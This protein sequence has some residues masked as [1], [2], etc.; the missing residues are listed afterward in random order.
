MNRRRSLRAFTLVELMVVVVIV[1][2]LSSLAVAAIVRIKAVATESTIRNNLRQ[3]YQA[4]EFY[5]TEHGDQ[6]GVF[7]QTLLDE[8]YISEN[9]WAACFE[10]PIIHGIAY[11]GYFT[12]DDSVW[13]GPAVMNSDG[14]MGVTRTITFPGP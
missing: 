13:A 10:S 11:Q 14:S 6:A 1:G 9:T 7:A 3:I 8:K 2:I 4:K 5:F 12:A